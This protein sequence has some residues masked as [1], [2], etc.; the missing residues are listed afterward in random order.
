M[1]FSPVKAKNKR[2]NPK[3]MPAEG[4]ICCFLNKIK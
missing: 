4:G 3:A 2:S 1:F